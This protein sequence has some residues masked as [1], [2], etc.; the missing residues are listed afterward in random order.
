MP[1]LDLEVPPAIYRNKSRAADKTP[2]SFAEGLTNLSTVSDLN[3]I[4]IWGYKVFVIRLP[5]Y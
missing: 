5:V 3:D 4:E 1:D 2:F